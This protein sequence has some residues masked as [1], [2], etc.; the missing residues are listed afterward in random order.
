MMEKE[1]DGL[2]KYSGLE[3]QGKTKERVSVFKKKKKYQTSRQTLDVLSSHK[4]KI[5]RDYSM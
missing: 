4:I 2:E 1:S 5:G 3:K